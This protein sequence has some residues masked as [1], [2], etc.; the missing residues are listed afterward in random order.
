[1]KVNV[2]P[3]AKVAYEAFMAANPQPRPWAALTDQS[4]KTWYRVAAAVLSHT[5][6]REGAS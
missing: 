6:P 2:E 4:K 1:V 3:A 5:I